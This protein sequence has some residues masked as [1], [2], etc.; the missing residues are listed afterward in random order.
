MKKKTKQ[1]LAIIAV[2]LLVALYAATLILSLMDNEMAQSLFRG[3]VACTILIPVLLYVY[4]MAYKML[5]GKGSSQNDLSDTDDSDAKARDNK[6]GNNKDRNSKDGNSSS[7][8]SS[9]GNNKK[10]NSKKGGTSG[11]SK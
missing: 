2:I 9:N 11:S 10:E 4:I 3:A 7:G 8:N 5:K 1:I 6:N